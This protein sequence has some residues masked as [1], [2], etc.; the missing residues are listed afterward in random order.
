MAVKPQD[1]V[2][3]HL[4]RKVSRFLRRLTKRL[5]EIYLLT[6]DLRYAFLELWIFFV[7]NVLK[8]GLH[9]LQVSLAS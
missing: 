3:F 5:D 9:L 1:G 2:N 7:Q 6:K 8:N 4:P